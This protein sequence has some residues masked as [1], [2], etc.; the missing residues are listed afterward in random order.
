MALT[1]TTVTIIP[2]RRRLEALEAR[3]VPDIATIPTLHPLKRLLNTLVAGHL[4]D[5][6]SNGTIAEGM[7]RGLGYDGLRSFRAALTAGSGSPAREDLNTR[8]SDAM[9]RLFALK[10]TVPDCDPETFTV[11]VEAL[12]RELPEHMREHPFV[13]E[14]GEMYFHA[15][16]G[17]SSHICVDFGHATTEY[18]G[19][20]A[21]GAPWTKPDRRSKPQ[22]LIIRN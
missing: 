19:D 17:N 2:L 6:G 3:A 9:S 10:G 20:I 4:G 15:S 21:A 5:T 14:C 11:T 8:W 22:D 13:A 12:Y 7:A 1:E 18:G 16:N